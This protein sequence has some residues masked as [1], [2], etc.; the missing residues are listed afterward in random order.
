VIIL[1]AVVLFVP[2]LVGSPIVVGSAA[3]AGCLASG[4]TVGESVC[5]ASVDGFPSTCILGACACSAEFSHAVKTCNC[6]EGSCFNGTACMKVL[7]SFEECVAAGYPVMESYPRQCRVPGG[8]AFVETVPAAIT[9]ESC[10]TA[11]GHWNECSSR[12]RLDSSGKPDVV[13]PA[14]CEALCECGGIAGFQCPSGFTCR[15]PSGIA[16]A[17]GYCVAGG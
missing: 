3:E 16:D 5:C 6:P 14:L 8:L 15:L 17:L 13:C 9:A 4:G 10:Q 1:V 12:C 11:G 7:R 2:P